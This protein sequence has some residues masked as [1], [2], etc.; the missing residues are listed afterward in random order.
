MFLDGRFK[1]TTNRMMIYGQAAPRIG[2]LTLFGEFGH[3]EPPDPARRSICPATGL[4]AATFLA[5][6]IEGLRRAS[7]RPPR[8]WPHAR[9]D[10]RCQAELRWL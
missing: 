7:T 4:E 2:Y 3:A 1:T 9:A 10:H 8:R 5:D 6:E